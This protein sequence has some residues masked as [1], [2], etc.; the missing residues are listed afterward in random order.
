M[1][2][3]GGTDAAANAAWDEGAPEPTGAGS[4]ERAPL[5]ARIRRVL[6]SWPVLAA[7]G[8]S[9]AASFALTGAGCGPAACGACRL[10]PALLAVV[11]CG[12]PILESALRALVV[13][14]QIRSSLLISCAM[15]SCLAIGQLFAAGEVAFIMAIGGKLEDWT[16]R[17]ARR[18][19]RTLVSLVPATARRIVTCPQCRA[20]GV[21]FADVPVAEVRVGDRLVIRD[22]GTIPVDGVVT[23]GET[24]VDQSS[25]TG[26]SEP[27]PKKAGDAVYSGTLN[28]LGEIT[29]RATK[30]GADSTLQRLVKMVRAAQARK[31][32]IQRIADKWAGILVPVALAIALATFA[33]CWMALDDVHAAL[34]RGVTVMV[35]FCPCALA[36]STPTAIMAAIGQAARE[37]VIVKSGAALEK[38]GAVTLALFDKTGTLQAG[39]A[40]RPGARATVAALRAAG[41]GA[42]MLSGDREAIARRFAAEAGIDELKSG[43]LPEDKSRIVEARQAAGEVVMMVGDGVNDALAL[44]LADVGVAMGGMGTDIAQEYADV[45]LTTDDLTKLVYLRR[46]SVACVRLIRFNLAISMAINAVAIT[47]SVLGILGPVSGALVHNLGSLLVVLN[48]ALLYDRRFDART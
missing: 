43:C 46:L 16:V 6:G 38:M 28:R 4:R 13:N 11:L 31:A 1:G 29:I 44:K 47:C 26:E 40:L 15:V 32:P 8:L 23:E 30:V 18:G 36:L 10:D 24:T 34:V 35:V 41:V 22:G 45:S 33:V 27:V 21:F 9:L 25:M 3:C 2:C 7:S 19:L 42:M 5:P 12:L 48:A 17:R 39:D 20:K 14:R 37:G